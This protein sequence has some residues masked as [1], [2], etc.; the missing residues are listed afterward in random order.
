MSTHHEERFPL[1]TPGRLKRELRLRRPPWWMV[2]TLVAVVIGTWIP[3]WL[4]HQTRGTTSPKPRV[5]FF[6]D[7]DKQAKFGPQASHP[8]FVDGRAMRQPVEGTIARGHLNLDQPF[9]NGFTTNRDG[10]IEFVNSIPPQVSVDDLLLERGRERYGIYCALCHGDSGDGT[11]PVNRVAIERKEPKWV[12]ATNLLTQDIRDRADGQIFQAIRDGVR[13]MPSYKSQIAP[14]DRWA[15]VA[16]LRKLQ[17]TSPVAPPTNP[18]ATSFP[19]DDR[20]A[21]NQTTIPAG[22]IQPRISHPGGD[23]TSPSRRTV[24]P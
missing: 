15:I 10:V 3:L 14:R 11:G 12:P 7:M 22:T 21:A 1:P 16:H 24:R 5:H 17:A 19:V 20:I 23:E 9:F 8:W 6:H 18:V 2:A 4:I 13:N